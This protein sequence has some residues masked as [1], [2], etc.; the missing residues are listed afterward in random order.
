MKAALGEVDAGNHV[1]NITLK[2]GIGRKQMVL[3]TLSSDTA[4]HTALNLSLEID[5]E[6][7]H[8]WEHG[9]VFFFG[10]LVDVSGYLGKD[11][12]KKLM[13]KLGMFNKTIF[14]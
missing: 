13:K 6:L 2:V 14:L 3:G 7:S 10:Y 11:Q 12:K 4:P 1:E 8:S 5:M 9:S